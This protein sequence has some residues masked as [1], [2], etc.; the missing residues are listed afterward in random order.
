MDDMRTHT[1][2]VNISSART[3]ARHRM[4]DLAAA[5]SAAAAAAASPEAVHPDYPEP[6]RAGRAWLNG[7]ELGG[8]DRRYAHLTRAHD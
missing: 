1:P 7:Q 8:A 5:A 3:R 2:I 4:R 6:P